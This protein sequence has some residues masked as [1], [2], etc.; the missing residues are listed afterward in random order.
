M[1]TCALQNIHT[2]LTPAPIMYA[3]VDH[4]QPVRGTRPLEEAVNVRLVEHVALVL[5]DRRV[6]DVDK[7]MQ[8]LTNYTR[9][10]PCDILRHYL[11][12]LFR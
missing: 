9:D 8:T 3:S 2:T 11:M 6:G 10:L 5:A 7:L 12:Q 1:R 4:Q